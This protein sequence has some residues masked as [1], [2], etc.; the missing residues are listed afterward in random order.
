M[1]EDLLRLVGDV[2]MQRSHLGGLLC[3]IAASRDEACAVSAVA[4][5]RS[6]RGR[7]VWAEATVVEAAASAA[8]ANSR[9]VR[10]LR[11]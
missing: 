2:R 10:R 7:P 4:G 8:R 3:S 11:T 5:R 6:G 1:V 9:G